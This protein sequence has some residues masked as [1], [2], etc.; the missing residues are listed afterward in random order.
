MPSWP[1]GNV[2]NVEIIYSKC[3]R[4]QFEQGKQSAQPRIAPSKF[5]KSVTIRRY[6]KLLKVL[7]LRGKAAT[8][9]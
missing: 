7:L 1:D 8:F 3:M 9:T 6:L 2:R 5:F 4:W